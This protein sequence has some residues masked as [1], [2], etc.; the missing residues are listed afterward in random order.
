MKKCEHIASARFLRRSTFDFMP[1]K[2]RTLYFVSW[3]AYCFFF[4]GMVSAQPS[5]ATIKAALNRDH[6]LIGEPIELHIEVKT[7]TEHPITKWFN[8]PDSFNHLEVLN[9]SPMDSVRE[10]SFTTYRQSFTITGFDSGIWV[11]PAVQVTVNKKQI[12]ADTLSVTIVPVQL[13]D[14]TYHDIREIIDVPDE[15]MP[16]WYWLAGILS[17]ILLGV[18]VW[19]WLKSRKSKTPAGIA[20]SALSPLQEA[21]NA[22]RQLEAQKLTDKREWKRY[23]SVLTDVFK[24]YMERRFQIPAMQKTTSDLLMELKA[25]PG[26]GP[27]SEIAEALRISDAVKFAKYQPTEE[28]SAVSL[29]TIEQ[30][31]QALDHL[32][33]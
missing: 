13:K 19:L 21:L 24:R 18:L 32:K 20:F 6:V 28:Q 9:R 25:I 10:S 2:Q 7:N 27:V 30:T 4:T 1:S 5:S 33:S 8:L 14:S 17:F 15:K 29:H 3:L 12:K 23:Y 11:I 31:I 16:W 26:H 22:L